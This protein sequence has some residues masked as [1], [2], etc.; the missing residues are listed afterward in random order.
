METSVEEEQEETYTYTVTFNVATRYINSDV[1]ETYPLE[2]YG[3]S[4]QEWDAMS[5]IEQDRELD[6]WLNEWYPQQIEVWG[7]VS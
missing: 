4:D 7:D 2:D 6:E 1:S 3:F 5:R